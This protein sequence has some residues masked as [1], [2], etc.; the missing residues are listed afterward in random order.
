MIKNQYLE[1]LSHGTNHDKI[2]KRH[3]PIDVNQMVDKLVLFTETYQKH[4]DIY[5]REIECMRIQYPTMLC[6]V[7]ASDLFLGRVILPAIGFT[8]QARSNG[9]AYYFDN[10]LA[11]RIMDDPDITKENIKRLSDLEIF[12]EKEETAYKTRQAY[13]ER[14]QELLPSDNWNGESG[15]AFP[16][17]RMSGTHLHYDKLLQLGLSGLHQ[18]INQCLKKTEDPNKIKFYKYSLKTLELFQEISEYTIQMIQ[19]QIAE[20]TSES[21]KSNLRD[22]ADT[23]EAI[24]WDPPA[25]L[26]QAI[27]L[28]FLWAIISGSFNYGRM[29]EYLGDF[30]KQ[31]I[32]S[33][34]ITEDEALNYLMSLFR[35]ISSRDH[36]FDS[37]VIVGGK[38][39]RNE[40]NADKIAM[41][42]MEATR[43]VHLS[44]PQMTL[45][46]YEGQNLDIYQKALDVLGEGN[47][48]PMLYNDDVNIPAV[49]DAFE[50]PYE[51]AIHY[52]PFG[53]G[54]Y[55]L[56][57]QSVGTPSGVINLLS[58]LLITLHKGIEPV[59]NL[60]FGLKENEIGSFNTFDDLYQTYQKQVEIHVDQLAHQEAIE[61]QV[62]GE[63]A[64][65]LFLSLLF[66][67]CSEKGKPVF[68]GG[69]KHLGGTLETYGNTNTA[70]SLLAIKKLVFEDKMMTLDHMIEILDANFKGYHKEHNLMLNI[71]KYGNDHP[72]ADAMRVEVDRHVC[73]VTKDSAKKYGL[74]SYLVVNIN[75]NANTIIGRHT[76]A[77]PDGRKANTFMANANNP[78]GGMDKSG[79]TSMLNSLVKPDCHLHAGATQNMKFSKDMFST[80]RP[81]L[82]ALL[83][84]Y[85]ENGGA[86]VMIT[87]VS[88]D[89]LQNAIKQPEKYQNLIVRVGGFSARFIDLEKDVQQEI[90]SRTLY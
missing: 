47:T 54:E 13:P 15:I 11:T 53:C 49:M 71:P 78:T 58:S 33:G 64:P 51:T 69:V 10:D 52:V 61:Y 4:T 46:F 21:F 62:A 84:T 22:I 74:D 25:N 34:F 86:Q 60:R 73:Q 24:K 1:N 45:R 18:E 55:V 32:E 23:L 44:T 63:T 5:Q 56:H 19:S 70:D 66:D 82:E 77:S 88:K 41:L 12:W 27:Q 80:Y 81:Q 14:M 65:F 3:L 42:A 72:E 75:N 30:I 90:L 6:E 37:R 57:H 28:M 50:V 40:S 43:Q 83:A 89:D 8:P 20:E 59:R 68:Q 16:L 17:Y 29:D 39:R 76:A 2:G 7:D 67:N 85:Y 87:V 31:D 9:L 26:R 35:L 48:F 38:G 36:I 79:I